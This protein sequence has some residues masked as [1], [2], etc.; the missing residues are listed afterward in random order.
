MKTEQGN[1]G[2]ER[3]RIENEE[4]EAELY[5]NGATLTAWKPRSQARPVLWTSKQATWIAGKAIRGG[6]PLCFP[7][8]GPKAGAAQHGWARTSAWSLDQADDRQL[9][10]S[11]APRDGLA[12]RYVVRA[13][14]E[15]ELEFTAINA[16]SSVAT[17]EVALHA[18]FEISDPTA[19]YISGLEGATYLDRIAG[20]ARARQEGV[21][22]I[23]GEVDRTFVGHAGTVELWD[24]GLR[25][26]I[27]IRK[28]R[29][30][31]TVVW[32]PW[33]DKARA[34]ADFGDEE[35]QQMVCIEPANAGE[36]ALLLK[37]GESHLTRV[38]IAVEPLT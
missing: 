26:K 31:S 35:Y 17:V 38:V 14:A 25:R 19:V 27:I 8:F 29:S 16:G 7:W 15:L 23:G 18:Y 11:L 13:G 1:G 33:I 32:N 5:L 9:V 37:P 24:P 4:C 22:T 20:G 36:D 21:V 12:A 3:V 10:L 2:L 34:M 6:V 30:N 28:E